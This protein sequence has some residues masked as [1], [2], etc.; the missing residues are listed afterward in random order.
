MFFNKGIFDKG[1]V[2]NTEPFLFSLK[3]YI[4]HNKIILRLIFF[5]I[6]LHNLSKKK[7]NLMARSGW[8]TKQITKNK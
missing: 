3:C 4:L 7:T 6:K 1:S 2:V 5:S 8:Q